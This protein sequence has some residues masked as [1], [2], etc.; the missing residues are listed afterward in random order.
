MRPKE[1]WVSFRPRRQRP[2]RGEHLVRCGADRRRDLRRVID[3]NL[4]GRS[5]TRRATRPEVGLRTAEWGGGEPA[6]I[7]CRQRGWHAGRCA[8]ESSGR[9]KISGERRR[10]GSPRDESRL[11]GKGRRSAGADGSGVIA[12]TAGLRGV[13]GGD[14]PCCRFRHGSQRRGLDR[15]RS[16]RGQ[17]C[18]GPGVRNAGRGFIAGSGGKRRRL[19]WRSDWIAP[20]GR[21]THR[22]RCQRGV[23]RHGHF[24]RRGRRES[25]CCWLFGRRRGWGKRRVGTDLRDGSRRREL[26]CHDLLG[27]W[28]CGR[29]ERRRDPVGHH[30]RV[31]SGGLDRVG[32]GG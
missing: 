19:C 17:D 13:S 27:F 30:L 9:P 1:E 22:R 25:G 11:R 4:F 6:G 12:E 5:V 10:G 32:P 20:S 18:R 24:R 21:A 15:S 7:R 29:P 23:F 3:K 31:G 2:I 14:T 26:G 8:G 16:R 28:R